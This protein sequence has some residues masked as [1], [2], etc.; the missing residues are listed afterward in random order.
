MDVSALLRFVHDRRHW[1]VIHQAVVTSLG[2]VVDVFRSLVRPWRTHCTQEL[3]VTTPPGADHKS[4]C[5]ISFDK[6]GIIAR[7]LL[8]P[9]KGVVVLRV[10]KSARLRI[11]EHAVQLDEDVIAVAYDRRSFV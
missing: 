10:L 9:A 11:P 5:P 4:R 6:V 8:N 3:E 7:N 1:H 2:D